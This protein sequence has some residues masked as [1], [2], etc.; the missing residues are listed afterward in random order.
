[1]EHEAQELDIV[2]ENNPLGVWP[3]SMTRPLTKL[4]LGRVKGRFHKHE[5]YQQRWKYFPVVWEEFESNK[6][7][8][9]ACAACTEKQLE[10]NLLAATAYMAVLGSCIPQPIQE[11][12]TL[13]KRSNF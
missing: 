6:F 9:K 3:V 12:E 1:M 4:R 2:N 11:M 7:R 13:Y 8:H 5:W 10:T